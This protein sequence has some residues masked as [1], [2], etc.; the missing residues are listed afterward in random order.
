MLIICVNITH[1]GLVGQ[2]GRTR[3]DSWVAPGPHGESAGLVESVQ[4]VASTTYGT[5][6]ECS[7]AQTMSASADW[8]KR[9]TNNMAVLLPQFSST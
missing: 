1:R 2:A 5:T 7:A 3:R 4:T 6:S 8:G 9:A